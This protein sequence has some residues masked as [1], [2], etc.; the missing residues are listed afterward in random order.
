LNRD[1]ATN[2]KVVRPTEKKG[3]KEK[4]PH[5]VDAKKSLIKKWGVTGGKKK[6]STSHRCLM[7]SQ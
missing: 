2:G 3:R 5:S 6:V 7:E 4:F 1:G